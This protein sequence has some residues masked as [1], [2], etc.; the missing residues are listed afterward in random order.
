[1]TWC[2]ACEEETCGC[3]EHTPID[4]P[5]TTCGHNT[6][7]TTMDI[8]E[9]LAA[10]DDSVHIQRDSGS[11]D[12]ED[13]PAWWATVLTAEQL[14]WAV[15]LHEQTVHDDNP[16]TADVFQCADGVVD[17]ATALRQLANAKVISV[18][19]SGDTNGGPVWWISITEARP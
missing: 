7:D 2:I 15:A 13:P 19:E 11:R 17:T 18:F 14:A 6:K 12:P 9:Q 4:L 8:Y 10:S 5:C 1:M 3:N 16:H